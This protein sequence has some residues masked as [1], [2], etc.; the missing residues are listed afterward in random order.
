MALEWADFPSGQPGIYGVGEAAALRMLNGT[1]WVSVGIFDSGRLVEDPDSNTPDGSVAF[2]MG[3]TGNTNNPFITPGLSLALQTP[4][5][6]KVWTAFRIW[7]ENFNGSVRENIA[8]ICSIADGQTSY[9]LRKELNG[10]LTIVRRAGTVETDLATTTAPALTANAWIHL[11]FEVNPATGECSVQREGREILDVTDPAP[12]AFTAAFYKSMRRTGNGPV[13]SVYFLKDFC[14]GNGLGA[15]NTGHPG[16]VSV[17]DLR[18]NLDVTL[19]GWTTSSGTTGFDLINE[20]PPDDAS[21][22][23]A[24]DAPPAPAEF[25]LTGLPPDV[26]S[27][28]GLISIVRA[29]KTDGG[30]GDL[31]VALTPNG[32]DY[33]NGADRPITTAATYWSDVSQL[34]PATTAPWSP[35]EVDTLKIRIDR[36]L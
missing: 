25:E 2:R 12:L 13:G 33:D 31:Q 27:V 30:D 5:T 1:P 29:R 23:A 36:T 17:I 19:G 28:R 8:A 26:T 14:I 7:Y 22:I 16:S 21:F 32:T 18:P 20:T 6:G 3:Q 34:S 11:S 15:E 10:A 35:G 4:T 9:I 24:D